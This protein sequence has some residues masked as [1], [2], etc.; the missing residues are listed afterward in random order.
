MLNGFRNA[1]YRPDIIN[2]F[3]NKINKK[4]KTDRSAKC[5]TVNNRTLYFPVKFP[6]GNS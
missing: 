2:E 5:L 4:G 3:S 6:S 1:S